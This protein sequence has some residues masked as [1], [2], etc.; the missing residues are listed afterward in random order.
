MYADAMAKVAQQ[1]Q[2]GFVN[3]YDDTLKAMSAEGDLT[4][5]GVHLLEDG[6]KVFAKSL[7][8]QTLKLQHQRSVKRFA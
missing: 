7:F 3:V 8:E 4:S 2:V 6:Y 1:Q 5:N